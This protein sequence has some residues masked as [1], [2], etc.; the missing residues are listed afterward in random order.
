[1]KT[2]QSIYWSAL[3]VLT[4]IMLFSVYKY[5][6]Q[7]E[8]ISGFFEHLNYP[9][10]LIYPLAI[11]KILGLI[12]IWGNFSPWLKEWAYAGFFFDTLLAF[13]AHYITDGHN[14]LFA[15]IGLIAT[16]SAY[17]MGRELRP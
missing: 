2:Q 4:G 5:F 6:T 16:L 12:A 8:M 17:F 14:Y 7:Y 9:T 10:Y 3:L 13:F 15:F 11:A 1:M